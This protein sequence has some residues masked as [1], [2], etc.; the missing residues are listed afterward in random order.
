MNII[1]SV[2]NA[3]LAEI[4]RPEVSILLGPRQVGKTFLLNKIQEYAKKLRYKTKYYNLELPSDLLEFSKSDNDIFHMLTTNVD[5]VFID[6][7]HYLPNASHIFKAI[8]DSNKKV[9]IFASGSSSIEIH[10]HLKESLAGRRLVTKIAPFTFQEYDSQYSNKRTNDTLSAY[11]SFGGMPGLIHENTNDDKIRLL[12]ELLET[13]I[14]KDIKSLIKEENIRAFNNLIYL[15]AQNQGSL[16]SI[17][18]LA[19]E[20]GLTSRS[21]EKYINILEKTFICYPINSYSKNI[22][23][24]LKK[25][26]KI[27]LYDLGLR[28][29]LLKD[30]EE[31]DNRSDRGTI[32]ES[33]VFLQLQNQLKANMEL[34]FW[35]NKAGKEIDFVILKNRKPFLIE[36]KTS[37]HNNNAPNA[38]KSFISYYPETLGGIVFSKKFSG[39]TEILGKNIA[40]K[41]FDEIYNLNVFEN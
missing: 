22:G 29:A 2:Y 1:R 39:E 18:A 24:E 36:V 25:S 3:L 5:L 21:I 12:N 30:F 4:N 32:Y 16:V 13:Y 10:K 9:K 14:Q 23:S 26:R 27:Y 8:V 17:S 41:T 31:I 6:E 35:R 11:L 37:I 33:F 15:L 34:K 40:F 28:N 20:I 7:F 19:S 38:F